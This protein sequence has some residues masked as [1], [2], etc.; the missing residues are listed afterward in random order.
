MDSMGTKTRRSPCKLHI[1][2][3]AGT[4]QIVAVALTTEGV[5]DGAE[6]GPLLD[7]VPGRVGSFTADDACDQEGIAAAVAGRCPEAAVIV[8]P[9]CTAVPSGTAET[10]PTR[11]DRH[12]QGIAEHG[13]AAWQGSSGCTKRV[14]TKAEIGRFKQVIGD[15]LR[16]RTDRRRATGVDVAVHAVNRMLELGR[17]I[18]VRT[19]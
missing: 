1:G 18:S 17:P 9:C 15:G 3:D 14:R 7:Q 8:P 16:S 11:R 6:V 19:A 12:V 2:L 10:A 13:R 5:D 4:G